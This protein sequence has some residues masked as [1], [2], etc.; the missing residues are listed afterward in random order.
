M[1][2]TKYAR[3]QLYEKCGEDIPVFMSEQFCCESRI[4]LIN[5]ESTD[6]KRK[7]KT[8]QAAYQ[9]SLIIRVLEHVEEEMRK[10]R[11]NQ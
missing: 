2:N 7:T 11:K 3:Y 10:R 9:L 8:I 5:E 6:C 4:S 1:E